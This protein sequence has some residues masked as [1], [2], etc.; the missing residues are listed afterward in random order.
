VHPF[1]GYEIGFADG[2]FAYRIILNGPPGKVT[3]E[4]AEQIAKSL[5]D[6]VK[7]QPAP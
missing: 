2:V 7:G 6:R 5:Y 1:D 3:Q 4:E